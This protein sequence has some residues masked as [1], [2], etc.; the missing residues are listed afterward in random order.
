MKILVTG[1]KG[2]VGKNL[3]AQLNNIREG[4]CRVYNLPFNI[5]AV[6]EY[7]LDNGTTDLEQW[8]ADCDF[9]FNLAGVNRPQN[10]EEFML[11]NF[12]FASQL[13]EFLKKSGNT[14]PVMI[15]SSIQA[16]LDNP[17]GESKR[18]GEQLMFEY[19]KDTG[20]KVLVYR[21]PNLFGK[22]CRPNYNSAVATFCNNIANGLPIQVNDPNVTLR[23][24]YIDDVVDEMISA[25]TGTEHRA[26]N[27]CFVPVVHEVKL[28]E[29]AELL[30]KFK[31]MPQSLGVPTLSNAFEKALYSTFLS[32]FPKEKFIYPVKMNID[33]RGSY[34]ELIR[35]AHNGQF[36]VNISK[37]GITKGQHWHH[38]KNEKFIVVHGHGLI[39]LRKLGTDEIIEFEVCGDNIQ[40][41]EMIPGYTHNI[42]NL[43]DKE[44][45]VTV[46]WANEC[47]DPSRPDTYFEEV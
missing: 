15:S 6:Y 32:Y 37:P 45:L 46:M 25:L 8:C 29:I 28:G 43:S 12:G 14:C 3:C 20:A 19:A 18:A 10:P 7:D 27:F 22:W 17:Y 39:Q 44:D 47:F 31:E 13:L 24:C 23:L 33:S 21:F 2:F 9:V 34:T 36:A 41:V 26:G 30:Y 4:K 40:V 16:E 11:G 1:A 35:S 42:I 5:D 38:T